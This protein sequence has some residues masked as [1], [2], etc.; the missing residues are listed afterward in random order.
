MITTRSGT[1]NSPTNVRT[2]LERA[3]G[4]G[5]SPGGDFGSGELRCSDI[6]GA[7]ADGAGSVF[8]AAPG[9]INPL[10]YSLVKIFTSGPWLVWW[11]HSWGERSGDLTVV[12]GLVVGGLGVGVG[13]PLGAGE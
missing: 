13:R 12:V 10:H 8:E 3:G 4:D 1:T 7:G 6:G 2:P 11:P 9:A 5:T